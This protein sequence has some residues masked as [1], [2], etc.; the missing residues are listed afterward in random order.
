LGLAVQRAV[1]TVLVLCTGRLAHLDALSYLACR[2]SVIFRPSPLLSFPHPPFPL[3][4]PS[5]AHHPLAGLPL[6]AQMRSHRVVSISIQA[7]RRRLP[8][9]RRSEQG[10]QRQPY[11]RT[12]IDN[13]TAERGFHKALPNMSTSFNN[14]AN[15]PSASAL[16]GVPSE[17]QFSPLLP[18][19]CAVGKPG[20][21]GADD[22][23]CLI[24]L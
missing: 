22:I 3:V 7:I 5:F 18:L 1:R 4:G 23:D 10:S 8:R 14:I 21:Q 20:G 12:T 17:S 2:G 19:I 9:P 13:G 24:L 11:A 6:H 15:S 16:L